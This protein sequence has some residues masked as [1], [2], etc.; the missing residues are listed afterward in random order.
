M[1]VSNREIVNINSFT[2]P[3]AMSSLAD[4][5]DVFENIQMCVP[6]SRSAIT[7]ANSSRESLVLSK[8]SSIKYSACMKAQSIDSNWA[9][10]TENKLFQLSYTTPKG[11]ESNIQVLANN[12][13]SILLLHVGNANNICSQAS[14][15]NSNVSSLLYIK[16]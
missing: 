8:V 13:D 2:I 11:G 4:S 5:K 16:L 6:R 9:N 12:L 3:L 1:A 10:Q 14:T 7:N 15:V